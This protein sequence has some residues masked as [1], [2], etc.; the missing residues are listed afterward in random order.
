MDR[1]CIRVHI[2]KH[3]GFGNPIFST[4]CYDSYAWRGNLDCKRYDRVEVQIIT[5][6]VPVYPYT[7]SVLKTFLELAK[8]VTCQ[9]GAY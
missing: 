8:N 3:E 2:R 6:I 4:R 7:S 9:A 1:G 5:N